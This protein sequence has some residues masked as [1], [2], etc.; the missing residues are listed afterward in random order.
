[1]IETAN[2]SQE[3]GKVTS[4]RPDDR[5]SAFPESVAYWGLLAVAGYSLLR[6]VVYAAIKPFWFDEVLTYVVSRQGTPSAIWAALEKGVDGNPPTFYLLEHF[7]ASLLPNEHIGYRLL[8]VVG[9]V[10]ALLFLFVFLK[11]RY[12][13]HCALL[14]SS[15]LLI[16]PLFT[17]YAEEA[18]PYS[19]VAALIALAMVCYQRIPG[20]VW[21]V[22]LGA[23]LL[24]AALL[25][26]YSVLALAPFFIAELAL[27]YFSRQIRFGVWLALALPLV[28][29]AISWPRL[30]GMK[31]NWGLHFW[32][33][34]ALS[35]VSS[36]Y[37][38]YFRVGPP[39]GMAICG[40][41][42][43]IILLP[44]FRHFSANDDSLPQPALIAERV[45]IAGLVALPLIGFAVAKIAHGPFVERYFLPS[46]FGFATGAALVLRS[47]PAKTLLAAAILIFIALSSQEVG[48][49][50][51]LK[52]RE[53]IA[54]ITA[55]L[56]KLAVK[57]N[58]LDLPI[59][60]S[61]SGCFVEIWHYAPAAIFRRAVA[62]PDPESAVAYTGIDT[63]DKLVLALRP[64]GPPGIQDFAS[65]RVAHP[66]FLLYSDGSRYDWL[67]TRLVHDGY[68]VERLSWDL[69]GAAYLVEAPQPREPSTT[70]S[71]PTSA[72]PPRNPTVKSA[73]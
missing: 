5:L 40:L 15:L 72:A 30:M 33:G 19:L 31:Q 52:S 73:P 70:Y 20:I 67:A 25:H 9:F 6:S 48:F 32:A 21:T 29:I 22:G 49:W 36:A 28:P 14:C 18:R 1:M 71:L 56:T 54:S 26:Y 38:A 55:P 4:Q 62:L 60:L 10:C 57:S 23:S 8:S 68:R 53:T 59:V 61:D 46:I 42:I 16:T 58:F 64:Y 45:L 47:A 12:G 24:I 27:L 34:A 37:G 7:T 41:T 69:G 11:T 65:F 39:W 51:G 35:D 44:L 3:E 2:S 50:K 43:L 13:S 63:V 17:L 66:R